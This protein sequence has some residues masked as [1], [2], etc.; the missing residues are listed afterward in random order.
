MEA[1]SYPSE[2]E[3]SNPEL[4]SR[5]K[6]EIVAQTA[7]DL[8]ALPIDIFKAEFPADLTVHSKKEAAAMCRALDAASSKPWVI[9]SAG[10]D[11]DAFAEQ[12]AIAIEN[13]RSYE[14]VKDEYQAL[15]DDLWDYL[16]RDGWL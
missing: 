15:R 1:V 12:V 4:F 9:L 8:T 10:A 5:R 3:A 6:P 2:R 13:A 7:R 16:D 14:D 11:Y